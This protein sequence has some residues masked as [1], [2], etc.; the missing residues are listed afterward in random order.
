MLAA[1]GVGVTSD[2]IDVK[3]GDHPH[4]RSL[5]VAHGDVNGVDHWSLE[6]QLKG[7]K[8]PQQKHL[9]FEKVEGDTLVEDLE[10]EDD[11]GKPMLRERRTVRFFEFPD[12]A[13]DRGIDFT[14]ELTRRRRRR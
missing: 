11:D 10:W 4:H 3:G 6:K 7:G 1:D 9:K 2:Q 5:Y 14:V 12:A 8:Q 13:H